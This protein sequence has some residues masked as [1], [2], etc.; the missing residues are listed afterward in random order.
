MASNIYAVDTLYHLKNKHDYARTVLTA[1]QEGEYEVSMR[2]SKKVSFESYD[3]RQVF[4]LSSLHEAFKV[5]RDSYVM[6]LRDGYCYWGLIPKQRNELD[7]AVEN[8]RLLQLV[9][10]YCHPEAVQSLV[11]WRDAQASLEGVR[12]GSVLSDRHLR[13]LATF[14]PQN[15]EELLNCP[16][17]G[18]NKVG[19][20]GRKLLQICSQYERLFSEPLYSLLPK[21][22]YKAW[23]EERFLPYRG[24]RIPADDPIRLREKALTI[25]NTGVGVDALVQLA[26]VDDRETRRRVASAVN[27]LRLPQL[28][29]SVRQL[30]FDESP[31]VRQYVLRAVISS[32]LT[33]ELAEDVKRLLQIEPKPYNQALCRRIL[34]KQKKTD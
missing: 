29:K 31:Q 20:Y 12:R 18:E 6:L 1:L 8:K 11:R 5:Y 7:Q 26:Q 9:E 13:S 34:G 25:G 17:I 23:E 3:T 19:I 10:D 33:R 4:V 2:Y 28:T 24:K 21:Y 32:R 30:L 27:K 16:G 22:K 14:L 15:N